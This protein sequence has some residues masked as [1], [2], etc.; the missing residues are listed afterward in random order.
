MTYM[1]LE[2]VARSSKEEILNATGFFRDS[3]ESS[4]NIDLG[5]H[6]D[7]EEIMLHILGS[8]TK[9]Y[10][11]IDIAPSSLVCESVLKRSIIKAC[12]L[13]LCELGWANLLEAIKT[14]FDTKTFMYDMVDYYVKT[15]HID[16]TDSDDNYDYRAFLLQ[17]IPMY[18]E[19][20]DFI[21]QV[22]DAPENQECLYTNIEAE[23]Y[24]LKQYGLDEVLSLMEKRELC[25]KL[26]K[27][28]PSKQNAEKAKRKI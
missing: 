16:A 6:K 5:N 4:A 11:L 22:F 15:G 10:Y 26:E 25:R 1:K 19:H 24:E 13:S 18:E 2:D 7:D 27:N 21:L 28:L 12:D 9:Y 3:D 17:K 8:L 23:R 20:F 14:N